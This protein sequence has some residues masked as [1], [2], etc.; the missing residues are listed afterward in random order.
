VVAVPQPGT[1][2]EYELA[3]H[4]VS[5]PIPVPYSVGTSVTAALDAYGQTAVYSFDA[6]GG[7]ELV[8]E[9]IAATGIERVSVDVIGPLEEVLLSGVHLYFDGSSFARRTFRPV[10]SGLH[11]ISLRASVDGETLTGTVTFVIRPAGAAGGSPQ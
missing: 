7:G 1:F 6:L 10:S 11:T 3:L 4:R 9:G 2:P 5:E 8:I